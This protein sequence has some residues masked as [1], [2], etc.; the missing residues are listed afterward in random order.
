MKPTALMKILPVAIAAVF[1]VLAPAALLAGGAKITI[2]NANGPNVG[3][4][5]PTPAV[6]VG[7]NTGTTIGA[8]RLIAFQR[9]ADIWGSLLDSSVE[10]R[11]QA[12]FSALSCD[13]TS[14]VLGSSGPAQMLS[15]FPGA[16]VPGTLY[17]LALANKQEGRR[18]SRSGPND[19]NSNFN[20]NLG[21]ANCLAGAPWY[22]GLDN[23]HGSAVDLV[24]VL[25][26]EFGHGLG[27]LTLV[28]LS[29]GQ[30][31]LAIPDVFERFILDTT[32]GK[33]WPELSPTDRAASVLNTRHIV[34]NG[35]GGR[36]A[37]ATTLSPGTPLMTVN[38]PS[39]IAGTYAV[40]TASFGNALT[41]LGTSGAV[42]AATDPSDAA[43]GATTDACSPLT[44]ASSIAGN[45]AIVDRG[46][47][48]F[49]VK[50][51]NCQNAG[52][53]AMLV[54]DNTSD[55]PPSG[56]GGTDGSLTIPSV[57]IT[58]ADGASLRGSIAAGL[59]VTL[60]LDTAFL[61]GA[62]GSGRPLLNSTNP[63]ISGSSISHWDPIAFPNLLMEPNIN[64]D[65]PLNGVDLTLPVLRDI[66]WF[67]D[68]DLDGVPDDQ[69]NCV[70]VPNPDQAD[71]N[72]N[73]IGDPCERFITKSPRHGSTR[74]V[75]TPL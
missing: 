55:S 15:D 64:P 14:A 29:S 37:A 68:L 27:F 62:D 6:P 32:S 19:I 63:I 2:V 51:K 1:L 67:V 61:A 52:A 39:G 45:I 72:H 8:Q 20:V 74:T 53:I 44:N 11:I 26:H 34:W 57:R 60:R 18:D 65:L 3:F 43:G 46:T 56:L 7:G 28:N 48:T 12:S 24:H 17:P 5:D 59:N 33:T 58:Q 75:K 42:V 38:A 35:A 16:R 4:N 30:E 31:S 49:V 71:A 66:G 69:D 23:N 9:A 10:I 25:L 22:Y 13:A 73:G 21:A 47:C 54:A 70:N 40:G 50:A 36:A 41:S